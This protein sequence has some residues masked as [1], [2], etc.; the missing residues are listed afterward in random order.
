MARI[1]GDS[2]TKRKAEEQ[3][4]EQQEKKSKVEDEERG[5]K[6]SMMEDRGVGVDALVNTD[7][8][9]AKSIKPRRGAGKARLTKVR[10]LWMQDQVAKGQLSIVKVKSEEN[11]SDGVTTH[12][13]RPKTEQCVEA[14]GMVRRSV[15]REFSPQLGE[16][17]SDN[18]ENA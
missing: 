9:A 15:R 11:V 16:C 5:V 8:S 13:Y 18:L 1:S 14:W 4:E 3:E 17:V 7:S 6:R 2:S 12:V 10:E